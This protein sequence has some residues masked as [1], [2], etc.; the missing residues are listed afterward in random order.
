MLSDHIFPF[1]ARANRFVNKQL[2]FGNHKYLSP[3]LIVFGTLPRQG[4]ISIFEGHEQ[5]FEGKDD[6]I[7]SIIL[8]NDA[9][10]KIRLAQIEKARL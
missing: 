3:H 2:T 10:S 7:K 9:F 1:V 6:Y 4:V 8:L 5:I